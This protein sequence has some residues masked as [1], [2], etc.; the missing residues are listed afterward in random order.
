ML[1][2]VTS[3]E[4]ANIVQML[5]I[6]E[7][8]RVGL[9]SLPRR[10]TSDPENGMQGFSEIESNSFQAKEDK[11][12]TKT[13]V[14]HVAVYERKLIEK[15]LRESGGVKTKTAKSLGISRFALERRLKAHG[16]N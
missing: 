13:L 7:E 10:L 9:D 2:Q 16:I 3:R 6:T 11:A 14:E 15:A 5:V 4:L 1:G 8:G 12:Q